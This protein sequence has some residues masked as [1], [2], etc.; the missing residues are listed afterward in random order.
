MS[1]DTFHIIRFFG[2]RPFGSTHH[3]FGQRYPLKNPQDETDESV[4][5]AGVP[6]VLG[7][8]HDERRRCDYGINIMAGQPTPL[9]YPPQ[10]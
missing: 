3:L 8:F 4:P 9:T 5:A 1:R 2:W 7:S 6:E 10:K